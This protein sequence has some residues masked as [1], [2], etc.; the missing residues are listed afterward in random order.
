MQPFV[1]Y[2]PP[3][4]IPVT[5]EVAAVTSYHPDYRSGILIANDNQ[6]PCYV[7]ATEFTK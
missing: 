2:R 7:S 6:N 5:F 3:A 1:Y 4:G